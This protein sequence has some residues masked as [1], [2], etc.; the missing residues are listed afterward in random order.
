MLQPG[1]RGLGSWSAVLCRMVGLV[2]SGLPL[3]RV[4]W[5]RVHRDPGTRW[6]T[7]P[8]NPYFARAI[9]NRLWANFFGVGLVEA[10]DDIRETN[11]ASNEALFSGAAGWLV[12]H[13]YDLRALMREILQ[14][15]T[16]GFFPFGEG[17]PG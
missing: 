9:T 3:R 14:S 10:V 11:P 12:A 2:R 13:H 16:L 4:M 7:G 15:E 6:L 8:D 1:R 5:W 17:G